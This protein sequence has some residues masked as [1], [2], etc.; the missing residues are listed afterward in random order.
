M[1]AI[2]NATSDRLTTLLR[3]KIRRSNASFLGSRLECVCLGREKAT[4][5]LIRLQHLLDS[6]GP[7]LLVAAEPFQNVFHASTHSRL[8]IAKQPT[9]V[10]N[11]QNI[12]AQRKRAH[13]ALAS[14]LIA[15][16]R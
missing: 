7:E 1:M 14:F 2:T 8:A 5:E 6:L 11:Q 15:F 9:G 3:A 16:A 12:A 4:A 10:L 13:H